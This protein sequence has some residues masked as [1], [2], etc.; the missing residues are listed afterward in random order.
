MPSSTSASAA[1]RRWAR[2]NSGTRLPCSILRGS[3]AILHPLKRLPACALCGRIICVTCTGI[4]TGITPVPAK[5]ARKTGWWARQGLNVR[6]LRCQRILEMISCCYLM[7]KGGKKGQISVNDGQFPY[8]RSGVRRT[9]TD[10]CRG[11]LKTAKPLYTHSNM[12]AR[13]GGFGAIP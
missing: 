7:E 3:R 9:S 10:P 4:P 5:H 1:C 2:S 11:R 12:Y 6:P 13:H 8:H